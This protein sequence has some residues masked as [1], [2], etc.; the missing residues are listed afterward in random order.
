MENPSIVN[1]TGE[2]KAGRPVAVVPTPKMARK[3]KRKGRR[4]AKRDARA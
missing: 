2:E 4:R 1:L 3:Q